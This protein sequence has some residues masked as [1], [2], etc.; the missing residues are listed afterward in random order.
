M[1]DLIL[2]LGLGTLLAVCGYLSLIMAGI[3]HRPF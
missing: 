1:R 3:I 2:Y